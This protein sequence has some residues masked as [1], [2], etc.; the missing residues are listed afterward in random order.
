MVNKTIILIICL[1]LNACYFKNDKSS[2]LDSSIKLDSITCLD[3]I[4]LRLPLLNPLLNYIMNFDTVRYSWKITPVYLIRFY[5]EGNDTLVYISGHKFR[6]DVLLPPDNIGMEFK[7]GFFINDLPVLV[8]DSS[9]NLGSALYI[10]SNLSDIIELADKGRD[11]HIYET[12]TL[13]TWIY[14]VS[15]MQ[16]IKLIKIEDGVILK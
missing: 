13:P 6:P 2:S 1:I 4:Y 8:F 5:L 15:G 10:K 3:T 14:K 11:W 7:G 12:K 16:D 9:T